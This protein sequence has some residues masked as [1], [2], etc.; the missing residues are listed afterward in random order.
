[1]PT[2]LVP[3]GNQY[4][5][6]YRGVTYTWNSA[7]TSAHVQ[8]TSTGIS[9]NSLW[10]T[11]I[12]NTPFEIGHTYQIR[13][14]SSSGL[15]R[16]RG[17][18]YTDTSW[19]TIISQFNLISDGTFTIPAG[20]GGIIIRLWVASG[21]T[22]NETV[23]P[24][25]YDIT[26]TDLDADLKRMRE[27]GGYYNSHF[28]P[29]WDKFAPHE[30]WDGE[31]CSEIACCMSYSDD[32]ANNNI[33]KIFVS[34]Y[35]QGLVDQFRAHPGRYGTTASKGAF[36]WFDYDHDGVAD[37]T[38]RVYDIL[39]NGTI[40]TFEGNVGGVSVLGLQYSPNDPSIMGY[41]YPAYDFAPV[42][43]PGP[44]PPRITYVPYWRHKRRERSN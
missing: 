3:Q 42:P 25:I 18:A 38:G 20:T 29:I 5:N 12:G 13:Y 27:S 24:E 28:W 41:G 17:Y 44:G 37:H 4:T 8:G 16:F 14:S 9:Y 15:V 39:S 35:A 26:F 11:A 33:S 21:N 22:V 30:A 32:P 40:V 2:N 6:T 36:I 7:K 10:Q 19:S 1:M 34:N 31:S 23:T 43:T